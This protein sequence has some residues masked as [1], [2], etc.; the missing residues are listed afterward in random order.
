LLGGRRG[1]HRRT[2][3][4]LGLVAEEA[5][6]LMRPQTRVETVAR[7]QLAMRSLLDDTAMIEHDEAIHRR[8][9]RKAMR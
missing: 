3:H 8:D 7:E 2:L 1:R 6:A 9:R 4:R 5:A